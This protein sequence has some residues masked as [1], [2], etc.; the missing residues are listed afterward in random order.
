MMYAPTRRLGGLFTSRLNEGAL[1]DVD[2]VL[3]EYADWTDVNSWPR[4]KDADRPGAQDAE[5]V[6]PREKPGVIGEF[7]RAFT[8]SAAIEKFGLPYGR[9]R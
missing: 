4:R 8:I 6:D 3:G 9:V 2:A 1:L 5:R 7:N